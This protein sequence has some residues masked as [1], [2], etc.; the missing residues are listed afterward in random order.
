MYSDQSSDDEEPGMQ[1]MLSGDVN[2]F[3]SS[4]EETP[5]VFHA[6]DTEKPIL[7]FF[8][9]DG[10]TELRDIE[11]EDDVFFINSEVCRFCSLPELTSDAE[12]Y[13]EWYH[14]VQQERW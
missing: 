10:K 13:L 12:E 1:R 2:Y 5:M 4:S 7:V 8:S 11:S 6:G 3:S 14:E 9:S